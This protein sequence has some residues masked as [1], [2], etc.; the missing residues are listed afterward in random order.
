[1]TE[2]NGHAPDVPT[3][4]TTWT[5]EQRKADLAMHVERLTHE[6]ADLESTLAMKRMEL[7]STIGAIREYEFQEQIERQAAFLAHEPA[8]RS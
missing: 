2:P 1:M 3:V 5:R 6:V 7:H 8:E 4:V